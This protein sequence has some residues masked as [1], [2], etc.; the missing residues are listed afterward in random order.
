[1]KRKVYVSQ[2]ERKKDQL[3][4]FVA[5]PLIN[6][7]LVVVTNQLLAE[8]VAAHR[9]RLRDDPILTNIL[10]LPWIAN[11]IVLAV[12]FLL[13]PE[14]AVG[15]VAFIAAA[16]VAVIALSGLFLAACFTTIGLGLVIDQM[17]KGLGSALALLVFGGLMLMGIVFLGDKAYTL[18]RNWWSADESTPAGK[19]RQADGSEPTTAKEDE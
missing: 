11:G 9:G 10:P 2:R 1:M 6:L 12:A 18:A 14:F 7:A 8:A 5:F 17:I 19:E 15:Y 16:A 3:I 4:G 13:R